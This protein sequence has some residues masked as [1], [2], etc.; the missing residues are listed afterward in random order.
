MKKQWSGRIVFFLV[1]VVMLS[2]CAHKQVKFEY[3]N[4]K[5]DEKE[6]TVWP[7]APE[8]SRYQYL[9]EITGENNFTVIENSEGSL[10]KGFAWLG[11]LIFGEDV[12]QKLFRPQSGAFDS[13]RQRLYVTDVGRKKV[14]VFDLKNGR[15]DKWEGGGLEQ[16]FKTPIAIAIWNNAVFVTDADLGYVLK[17]KAD[18]EYVGSIGETEL[19]RPTGIAVDKVGKRFFVAD[20]KTH[21]IHVFSEQG[22]WLKAFGGKG[23]AD[24]KFNSPT[25]LAFANNVLH[26]SD[27]LN[28]RIQ[29]FTPDG[30]WLQS[31]GRR[32]LNVGNMPRPKGVAVDSDNN[33]YVVESYYDHLLMFN[34][35]GEGLMAIGGTGNRPGQFDLPAGVWIDSEDKIYV[36]DMFNQRIAV[37]QY[38]SR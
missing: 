22:K 35:N 21:Q 20:S 2:A 38:I 7:L 28:A 16:S 5:G 19:S 29:L 27:T 17:F 18:G 8:L 14:F 37:F 31:F 12:P 36:A 1:F 23:A 11:S 26:V 13:K 6:Q 3:I 4:N 32:G 34:K 10:R 9:G 25:H 15:V 30:Q 33:I 24:G